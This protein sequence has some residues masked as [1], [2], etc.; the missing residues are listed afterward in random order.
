[1]SRSDWNDAASS[2]GA[3]DGGWWLVLVTCKEGCGAGAATGRDAAGASETAGSAGVGGSDGFGPTVPLAECIIIRDVR[4]S[5]GV[6][7][8][9]D[10]APL[11]L[12]TGY[13]G[14]KCSVHLM[15]SWTVWEVGS[16]TVMP[17]WTSSPGK[18][19]VEVP[20]GPDSNNRWLRTNVPLLLLR[21]LM[22]R[23]PFSNHSSA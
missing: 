19:S 3:L 23:W 14:I 5:S 13:S 22:N 2:A 18:T 11:E 12:S 8:V 7:V 21:S 20:S 16:E 1:M 10:L 17:N 4:R 15:G 6:C 9:E